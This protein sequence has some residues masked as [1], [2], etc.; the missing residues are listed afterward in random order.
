MNA[1]REETKARKEKMTD[2]MV[3]KL[4]ELKARHEIMV[5][6]RAL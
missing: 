2:K 6:M 4:T 5:E 1:N 3:S